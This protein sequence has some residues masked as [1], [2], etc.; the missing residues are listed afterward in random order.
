MRFVVLALVFLFTPLFAG[1]VNDEPPSSTGS[2]LYSIAP[3][4][5]R[6][7]LETLERIYECESKKQHLVANPNSSAFSY[8]QIIDGTWE[9]IEETW[10]KDLERD[11]WEDNIA[12]CE[13]LIHYEG[14]HHW[15]SSIECWQL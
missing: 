9:H 12:A 7:N 3:H 2:V 4:Y 6:S 15:E 14:V 10:G 8:C 13:W 11:S 5:Y 1:T